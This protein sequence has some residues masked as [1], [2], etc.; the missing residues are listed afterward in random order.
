[1]IRAA[2][3]DFDGTLTPLTLDF[4]V[5]GAKVEDTAREYVDESFLASQSDQYILE[6]IHA[7]ADTLA[8][9]GPL[10]RQRA[11]QELRLLEVEADGANPFI[12]TQKTHFSG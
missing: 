2:I 5:L 9:E 8:G 11:F 7:V 12:H 3:F 1:M 4:S 6:M 10:F